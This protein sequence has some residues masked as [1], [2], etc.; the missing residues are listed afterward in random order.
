MTTIGFSLIAHNEEAHI[1][2]ALQSIQWADQIVVVD[3]ESTD[4][5][6]AIA[7]AFPKV[8]LFRQPNQANLNLN[9]SFGIA[10][11]TTDWIFYLDP[12]ERIP[13]PLAE[14]I[15]RVVSDTPHQAFRLPRRNFFFGRWLAHGGQYPDTQLRLFR[16]G[17]ARFP[18]R[19]VHESLEV[20]GSIGRLTEPFDHHPYPRLDDYLRKMNFYTSFQADFWGK[21]GRRPTPLDALRFLALRPASRFFRRYVLKGGFRDGWPGYI[22]ALG[23]AF[24]IAVSYAKFLERQAGAAPNRSAAPASPCRPDHPTTTAASPPTPGSGSAD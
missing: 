20:D 5:T 2:T 12:D 10:Q 15:R 19:H 4:R 16:R 9:K 13:A 6:A 7:S 22:A 17:K 11:L 23:D 21:E 14:E 3:C 1:A 8:R 18:N 24:Q